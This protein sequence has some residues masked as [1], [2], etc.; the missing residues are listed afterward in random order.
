MKPN[1]LKSHPISSHRTEMNSIARNRSLSLILL[2]FS[3]HFVIGSFPQ[4]N[5]ILSLFIFIQFLLY[6]AIYASRKPTNSSS[7]FSMPNDHAILEYVSALI[8]IFVLSEWFRCLHVRDRFSSIAFP[9]LISFQFIAC[10]STLKCL[11]FFFLFGLFS[12][13]FRRLS[14]F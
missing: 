9:T 4:P 12:R 1:K 13:F 14:C 7:L 3:L 2:A 8:E 6:V 10:F 11:F 5:L